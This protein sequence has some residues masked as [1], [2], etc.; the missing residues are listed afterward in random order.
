MRFIHFTIVVCV[1]S[2]SLHN[3]SCGFI[4]DAIKQAV[5]T[6]FG[7]I[8]DIPNRIPTPNEIFEFGKNALIGLPL[9]LTFNV[10]HEFCKYS[11]YTVQFSSVHSLSN[12]VREQMLIISPSTNIQSVIFVLW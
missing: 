2:F 4:R 5:H 11:P 3:G 9:E 10:I 8:K 7:V 6:T 1:L 12:F